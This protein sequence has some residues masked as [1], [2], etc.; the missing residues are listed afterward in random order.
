MRNRVHS[1][2]LCFALLFTLTVPRA[3]AARDT[4]REQTMAAAL[5]RLSL[6]A[7]VSDTDFALDRAPTRV[8]AVVMLLRLTGE[9]AKAESGAWKHPFKDVPDWADKYVGYAYTT[10][11]AGG[12]S[13]TSFGTGQASAAVYLTFVLRALGY[14][15]RGEGAQFSW[16]DPFTLARAVGILPDGVCL[17]P[18][19]RADVAAV[20][21]AALGATLRDASGTL[22][23]KLIRAGTFT[24][25]QFDLVYRAEDLF[26]GA[27]PTFPG[28]ADDLSPIAPKSERP[29]V[30]YTVGAGGDFANL[31]RALDAA[32]SR[33][34]LDGKTVS[35][36]L[37]SGFVV[38]EQIVFREDYSFCTIV[39]A[40]PV[41]TVDGNRIRSITIETVQHDGYVP[42]RL[43]CVFAAVKGGLSP[44]FRCRFSIDRSGY[45]G[46]VV[47]F[48]A[49]GG[50]TVTVSQNG[51]I[52]GGDVNLYLLEGGI[53]YCAGADFSG[54]AGN[55]VSVFRES[56][57]SFGGGKATG[58]EIGIYVDGNS[59]ADLNFANF[60]NAR[61]MGVYVG[62]GCTVSAAQ[63]KA[64]D[65]DVGVMVY[66]GGRYD[67][68]GTSANNCAACGM[69]ATTGGEIIC[70]SSRAENCGVAVQVKN[71]GRVFCDGAALR[72]YGTAGILCD[73][74]L[75]YAT[76][77]ALH[78][79]D[80]PDRQTDIVCN[81]G[82]VV[83]MGTSG[84]TN[85][86]DN[87]FHP[88]EGLIVR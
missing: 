50:G 41:V 65:C 10:G 23:D 69:Y 24:R 17:D 5:K 7:G 20:S 52:T 67:G 4:G 55:G 82:I 19:L 73:G 36:R 47:G 38:K 70:N 88:N 35:L 13:A 25:E 57:L 14:T 8:E 61:G 48:G 26:L 16:D 34:K 49:M 9:A 18:F 75:I 29:D 6:F 58:C 66:G 83:A 60:S 42:V 40:D 81:R 31:S 64:D 15:D 53:G 79:P 37:L 86:P 74:G 84:G 33:H 54:A 1:L 72:G 68:D 76:S 45:S 28:F 71:G 51:G 32:L 85:V 46:Y 80:V 63:L 3:R 2:L 21:Y 43:P 78:A 87:A 27:E 62:G 39:S 11:L 56:R 22:A 44:T 30:E 77:C 12:E 59:V